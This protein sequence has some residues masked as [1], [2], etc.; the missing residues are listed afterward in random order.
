[1]LNALEKCTSVVL[2]KHNH[3]IARR[4]N[5]VPTVPEKQIDKIVGQKSRPASLD[6]ASGL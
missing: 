1:M 5:R 3:L 4:E 6:G 2:K